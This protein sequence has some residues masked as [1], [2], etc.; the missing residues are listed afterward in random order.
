VNYFTYSQCSNAKRPNRPLSRLAGFTLIEM[1]VTISL[2]AIILGLAVP[3][4][5]A[6]IINSR[7]TSQINDVVADISLARS[8]AATRGALVTICVSEDLETCKNDGD[9]WQ[10]GR[11]VFVDTNS[12][13]DRESTEQILKRT[14][15]VGGSRTLVASGFAQTDHVSFRP[16][17]GLYQS[18]GGS[19][20]LCDPASETGRT[21]TVAA[22]GRPSA[23]KVTCP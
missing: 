6:Y 15:S 10:S 4:L 22:T 3:D 14:E 21:V 16:Y 20:L 5:R 19:F 17:G 2:L 8:E 18:T 23:A 12:N 9:A 7:L 1:M 13:G 11:I